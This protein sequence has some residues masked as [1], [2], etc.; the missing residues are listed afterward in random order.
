PGMERFNFFDFLMPGQLVYMLLA[1]G[2]MTTATSLAQQRQTGSLRHLF[3][4][5][6]S[7]GAWASAQ[8]LANVFLASLQI[9]ILF[10]A[11]WL[12]FGVHVPYNI[13]AT[14]VTLIIC[15]LT[16]LSMGLAV[17]SMLRSVEATVPVTIILF[18]LLTMF[19]NAVMPM[20][21]APAFMLSLQK[22]M[23]SMYMTQALRQTMM[24]GKGLSSIL[25]DLAILSACMV[26]FGS[27]AL[28]RIR[29]QVTA[30]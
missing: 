4:T 30:A 19:G 28:W 18:L 27:L 10:T 26:G 5:P 21:D 7:M 1:A 15:S 17:G 2:M 24:Q 25:G 23:P 3:T 14:I 12:M 20:E 6:V 11:A 29:K 22:V 13:P 16:S 9:L 8:M